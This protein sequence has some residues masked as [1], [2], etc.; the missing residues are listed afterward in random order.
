MVQHHIEVPFP[1]KAIDCIQ[2]FDGDADSREK[3]SRTAG[4]PS[5]IFTHGAAGTLNSDATANFMLGFA[6]VLPILGFRGNINLKSR[7]KMFSAVIEHQGFATCLG[8]RSMGARAAVMAATEDTKAL[9]LVS[10]PLHTEKETRDQILLEID[11][12]VNVLFVEGDKD[13]MC[14]LS[15]LQ[16]VRNKM[17]S[18]SWL[19]VVQGAD[20]GMNISP[21][22]ASADV[23]SMT[24]RI[25]AEWIESRDD[26]R[27]EGHVTW[28]EEAKWSG[29]TRE[30]FK[31]MEDTKSKPKSPPEPTAKRKDAKSSESDQAEEE[32]ISSR[33]RKRRKV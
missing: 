25:A 16:A 30:P 10:Y 24:G 17:K 19:V 20:H 7:V 21:K 33:T 22:S 28:D 14:D 23:V 2:A 5:M 6:K 8:G 31:T 11:P 1:K 15:S 32:T 18:K 9:V 3:V 29:W 4:T 26:T 27:R 13:N 12:S